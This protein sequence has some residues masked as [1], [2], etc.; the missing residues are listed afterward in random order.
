MPQTELME[1]H[2]VR[3][4]AARFV[5]QEPIP[6]DSEQ[7]ARDTFQNMCE[8]ATGY[9][10]AAADVIRPLLQPVLVPAR[11]CDCWGC[12]PGQGE[13][14]EEQIPGTTLPVC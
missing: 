12:K 2:E 4:V 1:L 6:D 9:G 5:R 3:E 10:L 13:R 8:T 11:G 14:N 7:A